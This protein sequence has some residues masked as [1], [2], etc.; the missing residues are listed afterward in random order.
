MFQFDLRQSADV[1]FSAAGV[2]RLRARNLCAGDTGASGQDGKNPFGFETSPTG[3]VGGM[4]RCPSW[5][6][7]VRGVPAMDVF[8]IHTR[9]ENI[10][11]RS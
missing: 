4:F 2:L 1:D 10:L 8:F 9:R 5:M 11:Q 3:F 7:N 6:K